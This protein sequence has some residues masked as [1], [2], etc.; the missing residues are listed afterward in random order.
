MG[1][2][3]GA[4]MRANCENS[5]TSAF[6][7]STSPTI[8]DVHSSTSA[9]VGPGRV[10]EVAPNALGA[11]LDR[12][13]RV[14][15]LVR[16]TPRDL[17]PRGDLLR[18]NQRRH[19]VEHQHHAV[20]PFSAVQRRGDRR[21]LQLA[22]VARQRDLLRRRLASCPSP[23]RAAAHRTAA[24]S[25]RPNTSAAGCPTADASSASSRIAALLSVLTLPA[26]IDRH[27]ARGNPLED[28][29]DVA[30]P[31]LD[32]DVFSLE[33]DGRALEA[34]AALPHFARHAVER[35]DERSELVVAHRFAIDAIVEMSGLDFPR[36][37]R[38]ALHRLGDPLGEIQA[39]PRGADE[40]HQRHHQ[41]EREVDAGERAPQHAQLAVV[42]VR[43]LNAARPRRRARRS[44]KSLAIDDRDRLRPS[45]ARRTTAAARISSPPVGSCS[46]VGGSICPDA[47]CAAMRSA[48]ARA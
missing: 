41:E 34:P 21:Q 45:P 36:R 16:Q 27:D 7:E 30:P 20:G 15:D 38:E 11:Q 14:L 4:G 25:S 32:L 17:A 8:V 2:A 40:N 44:R 19:V 1:A 42:L 9:C 13:Q 12:R 18:A 47:A 46:G 6:S 29:F 3:R 28:R 23:R 35:F 39:H 26:G 24:R 22:I 31:P 5:S 10:A 48:T 33:I 43:V 37:R